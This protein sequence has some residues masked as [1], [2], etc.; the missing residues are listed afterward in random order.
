M[1]GL[2]PAV[3]VLVGCRLPSSD[4]VADVTITFA[5]GTVA[6]LIYFEPSGQIAGVLL[7]PPPEVQGPEDKPPLGGETIRGLVR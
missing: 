2:G 3:E 4:V 6:A 7:L 5:S 1:Q